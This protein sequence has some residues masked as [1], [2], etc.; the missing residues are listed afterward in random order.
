MQIDP[1][2]G[3]LRGDHAAQRAMQRAVADAMAQCR[4]DSALSPVLTDLESYGTGVPL[5]DCTHLAALFAADGSPRKAI[6][7]FVRRLV[8]LQRA[9]PLALLAFRHQSGA[10]FHFLLIAGKGRATLGLALHEGGAHFA[11]PTTATFSDAERH[12][13]VLA[14][15]GEISMLEIA[16]ENGEHA[17]IEE[18]RRRV[19]T[20]T[21]FTCSGRKQSRIVRS[22]ASRL[23][24]LRLART[25]EAML[26]A[27]Q[28][29]L[30][31]G[32]LVH[33]A[34]GDRRESRHEMM[35]TLLGR[36][37]RCDAAPLLADLA[38]QDGAGGEQ[39]RWQAL[40]ECLALESAAGFRAL[41]SIAE[42]PADPLARPARELRA[43]LVQTHPQLAALEP[44]SCLA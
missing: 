1:Q 39:F 40:R 25:G 12:E 38:V 14:G 24:V 21:V 42:D 11:A 34:C 30:P 33:R 37:G 7:P 15:A 19:S 13:A 6:E 43:N 17:M 32:R 31:S 23:L 29:A 22:L 4:H 20:G 5:S 36:M 9:Y 16:R 41:S 8:T 2:I 44:A 3:A 18:C 28:F 27:R 26:P 10:G 35:L